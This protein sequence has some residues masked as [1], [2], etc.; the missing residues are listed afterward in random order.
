MHVSY[1][2]LENVYGCLD[3]STAGA[4]FRKLLILDAGKASILSKQELTHEQIAEKGFIY[5]GPSSLLTGA[6]AAGV[7]QQQQQ[8]HLRQHSHQQ[9]LRPSGSLI[10][11]CYE[12]GLDPH[13]TLV[14]A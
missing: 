14:F 5:A 12:R 6:I 7:Q 13:G 4:H 8:Q 3:C 10:R 9:V 2:C 1:H 11:G